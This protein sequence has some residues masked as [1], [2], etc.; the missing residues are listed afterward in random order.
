MGLISSDLIYKKV[1][2][3][4]EE[5]TNGISFNCSFPVIARKNGYLTLAS[6]VYY[7]TTEDIQEGTV[8]R[9]T[10]WISYSIINGDILGYFNKADSD[11]FT[12][13]PSMT[14]VSLRVENINKARENHYET[15]CKI[16]DKL[17]TDIIDNDVLDLHEYFDYLTLLYE[18]NSRDMRQFYTALS[19][20]IPK[21]KE[22]HIKIYANEFVPFINYNEKLTP[23]MATNIINF[24]SSLKSSY[25]VLDRSKFNFLNNTSIPYVANIN[26]K[27]RLFITNTMDSASNLAR[28]LKQVLKLSTPLVGMLENQARKNDIGQ[29]LR[30]S[31]EN[32]IDSVSFGFQNINGVWKPLF[33]CSPVWALDALGFR[34]NSQYTKILSDDAK[35]PQFPSFNMLSEQYEFI[36]KL[37][38]EKRYK[39]K[40]QKNT[41]AGNIGL[42]ELLYI[43]ELKNSNVSIEQIT[44]NEKAKTIYEKANNLNIL[45]VFKKSEIIYLIYNVSTDYPLLSNDNKVYVCTNIEVAHCMQRYFNDDEYRNTAIVQLTGN[46]IENF[47]SELFFIDGVNGIIVNGIAYGLEVLGTQMYNKDKYIAKYKAENTLNDVCLMI[48]EAKIAISRYSQI[49]IWDVD[50]KEKNDE[51][52][53]YYIK[54]LSN[55][56]THKFYVPSLLR[57]NRESDVDVKAGQ[58]PP[59][60]LRDSSNRMIKYIPCFTD[61]NEFNKCYNT[62]EYYPNLIDGSELYST[63]YDGIIFNPSNSRFIELSME[64]YKSFLAYVNV[65]KDAPQNIKITLPYKLLLYPELGEEFT[66]VMRTKAFI[67]N[68]ISIK[69]FTVK[70]LVED[71]NLSAIA[72]YYYLILINEKPEE[73]IKKLESRKKI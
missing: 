65:I 61:I 22:N 39:N 1:C 35:G 44:K 57:R 62:K 26:G 54:F 8:A 29:I 27:T 59:Y 20:D 45:S 46:N 63:R 60:T 38:V 68:L 18:G 17:R 15:C 4:I 69:G 56:L 19:I 13:V 50:Y 36:D 33:T 47:L 58:I 71:Y 48:P 31:A 24:F 23:E 14:P 16:L 6:F 55:M 9:P 10:D 72:A 42:D 52:D 2:K 73:T 25:V 5:R 40:I 28:Y 49:L 34:R 21:E 37:V 66:K 3:F 30:A 53:T 43:N 70:T 7:Y 32:K 51:M 67:K 12:Y 64:Q 41:D 11:D